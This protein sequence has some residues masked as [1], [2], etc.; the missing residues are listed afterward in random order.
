MIELFRRID[1]FWNGG[2]DDRVYGSLR[3]GFSVVAFLNILQWWASSDEL[4]SSV[5][6]NSVASAGESGSWTALNLF[7]YLRDPFLIKGALVLFAGVHILLFFGVAARACLILSFFWHFSCQNWSML[8]SG[9]WDAVL[10]NV[11]FILLLSPWGRSVRPLDWLRGR[12][13]GGKRPGPEGDGGG[14]TGRL[15]S[16]R[17]GVYL[18]RVQVFLIYWVAVVTR[19]PDPYWRNGDFFGYYLLSD[20]CWFGGPW[21]LEAGWLTKSATWGTQLAEFL[22]PPLLAWRRTWVAGFALGTLLHLTIAITTPHLTTFSLSMVMIY[23]AFA[24]F[25]PA[26]SPGDPAN[27]RQTAE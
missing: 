8:A 25:K 11:C 20:F 16:P 18:L 6:F 7:T 15:M 5:G 10:G 26:P 19:L 14:G 21:I 23:L 4:L 24:R 1:R 17:Y 2:I 9:G 22:I 27:R 3:L 13:A 12:L